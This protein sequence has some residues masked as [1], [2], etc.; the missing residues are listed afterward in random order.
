MHFPS[1]AY[2]LVAVL[3]IACSPQ[4]ASAPLPSVKQQA[5]AKKVYTY[6]EQMPQLPGG[7][8]QQATAMQL[9]KPRI[10]RQSFDFAASEA[11]KLP[12]SAVAQICRYIEMEEGHP[13]TIGG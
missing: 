7:G 2:F 12:K 1:A 10:Q 3:L 6:V 4:D 9:M 8:R 5:E 13:M 11:V